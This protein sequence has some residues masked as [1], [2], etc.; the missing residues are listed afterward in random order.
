MTRRIQ[1]PGPPS[2]GGQAPSQQSSTYQGLLSSMH[3][4]Q[5]TELS[6]ELRNKDKLAVQEDD[7]LSSTSLHANQVVVKTGGNGKAWTAITTIKEAEDISSRRR[8]PAR[9][10]FFKYLEK[11]ISSIEHQYD[12]YTFVLLPKVLHDVRRATTC[13]SECTRRLPSLHGTSK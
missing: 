5:K 6:T 12:I 10:F 2:T 11:G 9:H 8:Q 7:I 3:L 4:T 13:C 1:N